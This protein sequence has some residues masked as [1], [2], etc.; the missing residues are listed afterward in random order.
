M[1]EPAPPAVAPVRLSGP[2]VQP[3][4]RLC[5]ADR[6]RRTLCAADTDG[7]KAAAP[8]SRAHVNYVHVRLHAY[9]G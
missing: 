3:P 4:C 5:H 7:I 1:D 8:L 2:G 9:A 6:N